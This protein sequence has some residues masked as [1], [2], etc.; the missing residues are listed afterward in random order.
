MLGCH[1]TFFSYIQSARYSCR[2]SLFPLLYVG[3]MLS[4]FSFMHIIVWVGVSQPGGSSLGLII[5]CICSLLMFVSTYVNP[6][7]V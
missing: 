1:N 2:A 3:A 7:L 4:R 5:G 6:G